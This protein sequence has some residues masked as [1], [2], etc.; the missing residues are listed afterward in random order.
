MAYK[1]SEEIH[2]Y[3]CYIDVLLGDI[4]VGILLVINVFYRH[5][6]L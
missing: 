6:L 2:V 5:Y 1:P 3:Q 4:P